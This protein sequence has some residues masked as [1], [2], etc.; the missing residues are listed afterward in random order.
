MPPIELASLV[1]RLKL[2]SS[3]FRRELV[4]A[5]DSTKRLHA[6]IALA[7]AGAGAAAIGAATKSIKAAQEWG[8][9]VRVLS[10]ELG[11]S[12]QEASGLAHAAEHLGLPIEA[13]S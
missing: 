10:R 3:T 5:Q 4:R 6:G 2:D 1:T 12:A 9:E 13:L 8:G 11:I 7:A